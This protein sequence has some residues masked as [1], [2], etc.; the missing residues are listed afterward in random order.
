MPMAAW[1]ARLKSCVPLQAIFAPLGCG[2]QTMALPAASMLMMLPAS[3]GSECVTGVTTPMTPN[4]A[5]SCSE[6]PFSPLKASVLRNSTPGM[7]SAMTFSFSILAASRPIFVSSSS[8]R[9]SCSACSVQIL[10]THA[11]ALR[12]SSRPRA[13]N[14]RWAA[15]AALTASLTSLKTPAPDAGPA[16]PLDGALPFRI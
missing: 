5:Y 15:T 2:L 7:R 11:T 4:G 1:M 13:S 9:P 3:V 8:S 14:V 6:M 12:R 16:L 10:R